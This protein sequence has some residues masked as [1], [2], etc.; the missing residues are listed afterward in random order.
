MDGGG[1]LSAS[2]GPPLLLEYS[3]NRVERREP[4]LASA[5]HLLKSVR[6]A[7][8]RARSAVVSQAV[9]P[10]MVLNGAAAV[11][12]AV[13]LE[14]FPDRGILYWLAIALLAGVGVWFWR[15]AHRRPLEFEGSGNYDSYAGVGWLA[16]LFSGV[17]TLALARQSPLYAYPGWVVGWMAL[18]AGLYERNPWLLGF[19]CAVM[20]AEVGLAAFRP[21]HGLTACLALSGGILA[22]YGAWRWLRQVPR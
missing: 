17:A 7:R 18:G 20:L 10:T 14:V 11:V 6:Q 9:G 12:L 19:G 2:L 4:P 8:R 21:A 15:R 1:A 5:E 16:A 22:C 13:L 3:K